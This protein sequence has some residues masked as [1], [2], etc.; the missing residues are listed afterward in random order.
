M[1]EGKRR[2]KQIKPKKLLLQ[3]QIYEDCDLPLLITLASDKKKAI[4]HDNDNNITEY[5]L[6]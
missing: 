3:P 2:E 6:L 5:V 1:T 4:T